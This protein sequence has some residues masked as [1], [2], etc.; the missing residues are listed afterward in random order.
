MHNFNY[1]R[2]VPV[3]GKSMIA[4]EIERDFTTNLWRGDVNSGKTSIFRWWDT[5]IYTRETISFSTPHINIISIFGGGTSRAK[6]GEVALADKGILFFDELPHFVI[7][8]RRLREPLQDRFVN[9]SRVNSKVKYSAD[10]MFIGAMNPCPCG[11]MLSK[12]RSC[13][14]FRYRY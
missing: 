5:E 4:K 13:R 14:C 8:L 1:G 11:N 2:V 3:S 12:V 10:F 9:I 7:Y 6:I